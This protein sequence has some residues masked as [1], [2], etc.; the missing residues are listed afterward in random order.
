MHER[1][2]LYNRMHDTQWLTKLV[3]LSDIFSTLNGL[4]LAL[5]GKAPT[6]FKV[7]D[8]IQATRMKLDLWCGRLDR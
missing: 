1:H 7:Q 4:N 8:K 6:I 5:Q 2:D 3:Y